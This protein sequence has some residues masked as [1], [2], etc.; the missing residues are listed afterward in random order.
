MLAHQVFG[1]IRA[2]TCPRARFANSYATLTMVVWKS[3]WP[4]LRGGQPSQ[5]RRA[6]AGSD[7][8]D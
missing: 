5:D 4:T 6:L 1:V 2:V 7:G 3:A 8:G